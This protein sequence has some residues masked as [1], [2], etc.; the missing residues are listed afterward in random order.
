M[1]FKQFYEKNYKK[2]LIVSIILLILSLSYIGYFYFKT[3]DI[4]RRDVSLTGG[5]TITLFSNISIQ[6]IEQ[7]LPDIDANI[8]TL[9]DNTGRQTQIIITVPEEQT[10]Q[11]QSA[12]ESYLGYKLTNENSSIESTSSSLSADFYKQ[13]ITA[14][15]LAFFW[16]AAVV[17]IIFAESR[18]LKLIAVI[19]NIL[20]GI[21][22]GMLFKSPLIIIF[23]LPLSIFLLY[24]Y[25]RYSI[26]SFAVML[27]AFADII[28]TLALVN[29]IGI[30]LSTAGIVAFL[31][32][33]G[34]SV[35]TDVLLTKRLLRNRKDTYEGMKGAFKTGTT[36]TLTSI[37]AVATAL[38]A[39]YSFG[40][41]LNQIFTILLI[42]LG[43]D[44]F[45]TWITNA[46]IIKWY[47][48]KKQ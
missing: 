1:N 5:T 43:F 2:L 21:F 33:I 26:P 3:G 42:G 29:L 39:I 48:S 10:Q 12:L 22:I 4:I 47:V 11:T 14:L 16:M 38:I 18:R 27:S 41:V 19:L 31:M 17:F 37:I 7:A 6:E 45:N 13:L 24:M 36:M 46:S 28:M 9:S 34:Y 25:I 23:L 40:S 35:D 8:R 20:F 44:L 32:I 15:I 30:R